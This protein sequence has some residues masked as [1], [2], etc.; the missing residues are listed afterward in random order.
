MKTL[1]LADIHRN[2]PF[3][4]IEKLKR[5][6]S[7]DKVIAHGDYDSADTILDLLNLDIPS[8]VLPG[9]HDYP[10]MVDAM[11]IYKDSKIDLSI[12]P[13]YLPFS[14]SDYWLEVRKFIEN[15]R[16]FNYAKKFV[17]DYENEQRFEHS[18]L[19][20]NNSKIISVHASIFDSETLDESIE[21]NY[22]LWER[23]Y[24]FFS[25]HTNQVIEGNFQEMDSRNIHI[26][27]RGHDAYPMLLE[28]ENGKKDFKRSSPQRNIS[29]EK[30]K[31]YI[32]TIGPYQRENYA[33]FNEESMSL[34]WFQS[35]FFY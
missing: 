19:L 21:E 28:K 6:K 31:Q 20:K 24:S 23:M 29:F 34:E 30:D 12:S 3:Y 4:L 26:I 10:L 18:E 1:L 5:E 11:R 35:R 22:Q 7:I 13:D 33:I 16:L 27:F 2:D 15:P 8:I 32:L 17:D 14:T 9:N 25:R